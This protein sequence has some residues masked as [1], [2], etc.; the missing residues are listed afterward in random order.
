MTSPSIEVE[1]FPASLQDG[2]YY[3]Y[4]EENEISVHIS[5]KDSDW[6][7]YY[8]K[9]ITTYTEKIISEIKHLFLSSPSKI[10]H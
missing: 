10:Y 3:R 8:K 1:E 5:Y 4:D 7:L 2:K 6:Y 9:E